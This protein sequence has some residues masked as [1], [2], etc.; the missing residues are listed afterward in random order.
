MVWQHL[1]MNDVARATGGEALY[2]NNGLRQG[3]MRAINGGARFYTLTYTP[4][5]LRFDN[6]WH[7]V[8]VKIDGGDFQLSYRRGDFDDGL[9][10]QPPPKTERV[11]LRPEGHTEKLSADREQPIIFNVRALPLSQ[12]PPGEKSFVTDPDLPP[13]HGN[14]AAYSLRYTLPVGAFTVNQGPNESI[15]I[16]TAVIVINR[17]GRPVRHTLQEVTVGIDPEKLRAHPGGVLHFDQHINLPSG[18]DSLYI[19]VWDKASRRLG[20]V[21]VPLEV[22]K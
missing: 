2:D 5:D 22:K 4:H 1:Q 14:E 16:Q 3:A 12:T 8:K 19:G 18:D 6:K 11:L 10:L 13:P 9:N 15:A 17:Y 7:K 21:Q 20:T